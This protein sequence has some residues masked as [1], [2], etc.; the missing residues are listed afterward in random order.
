[1][2][3]TVTGGASVAPATVDLRTQGGDGWFSIAKGVQLSPGAT[4]TVKCP[5]GGGHCIADAVLVE[6]VARYNDGSDAA[7]V[8]L[9]TMDA[10]VLARTNPP[11]HCKAQ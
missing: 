7:S 3:V 9:A 5:T 2:E 10:I 4:L 1:M 6:S 8:T 11:A